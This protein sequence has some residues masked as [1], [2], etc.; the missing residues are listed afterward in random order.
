M[1]SRLGTL[2]IR[3]GRL[4]ISDSSFFFDFPLIVDLPP[5][6]YVIEAVR[7]REGEHD[8]IERLRV[9]DRV[10]GDVARGEPLGF[11]TVQFAQ[12]GLCDRTRAEFELLRRG[13]RCGVELVFV[14]PDARMRP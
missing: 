3:S 6:E 12:L 14:E 11:V 13:Q 4:S 8:L 1:W 9:V 10:A 2:D 5:G 7:A